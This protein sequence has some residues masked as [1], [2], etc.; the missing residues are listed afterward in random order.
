MGWGEGVAEQASKQ[1]PSMASASALAQ[2][3]FLLWLAS[4]ISSP[5]CFWLCCFITAVVTLRKPGVHQEN[6]YL[7]ENDYLKA[8]LVFL[9]PVSSC[10]R[11]VKTVFSAHHNTFTWIAN[12][13]VP[14]YQRLLECVCTC[15]C[16][17]VHIYIY[18]YIYIYTYVT[19]TP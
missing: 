3:E 2:F 18:I 17:C 14:Q 9:F 7:V 4:E 13:N 12:I 5:N 6:S 15:L 1:H 11:S 8:E 16:V 10:S 19:N